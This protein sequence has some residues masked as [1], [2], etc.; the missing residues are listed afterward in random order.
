MEEGIHL[1]QTWTSQP[2]S[3][4]SD[5]DEAI[6]LIEATDQ[7]IQ[8]SGVVYQRTHLA[9]T[10]CLSKQDHTRSKYRCSSFGKLAWWRRLDLMP[11]GQVSLMQWWSGLSLG[12][13]KVCR[14]FATGSILIC[15]C[16]WRHRNAIVFE[17]AR[18]CVSQVAHTIEQE[19]TAWMSAGLFK[20]EIM[21]SF[22]S[23]GESWTVSE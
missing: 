4:E 8:K 13:R 3:V 21:S 2:F 7:N 23:V 14:D 15:W 11:V 17:G 20:D 19:G 6:S 18:P 10:R 12:G 16:L 9:Q 1:A 22:V 5:S